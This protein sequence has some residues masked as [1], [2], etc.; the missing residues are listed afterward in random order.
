[1]AGRS[2][3]VMQDMPPVLKAPMPVDVAILASAGLALVL[4]C[5]FSFL[6]CQLG[7]LF[8]GLDAF[9]VVLL[10]TA[11]SAI[12]TPVT[13]TVFKRKGK[14]FAWHTLFIED[15]LLVLVAVGSLSWLSTRQHLRIFMNPVPVPSGVRVHHGRSILFSSYVHFTGSPAAIASL[16]HSKG[17]V[18]LP[19]DPPETSDITGFS[20][21]ERTK[22]A[23]SWWQP[24]TMSNPRFFFLHHKSDAVQGWSEGWWVSGA[25]SEVY[26]FIGG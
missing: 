4:A 7:L 11:F 1:M 6:A 16:L 9:I 26:A 13:A 22:V 23:W 5:A 20:S 15:A 21:R 3:Y 2:P 25:M 8:T 10:G 17:L 12:L 18:E 19:A 24:A 14:Y